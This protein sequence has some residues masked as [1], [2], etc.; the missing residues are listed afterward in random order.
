MTATV[1]DIIPP[2]WQHWSA[3]KPSVVRPLA[4]GLTN[5]SF[6]L[7]AGNEQLVLRRNSAISAAL[8]LDR[9][10]ESAALRCASAAGLC[11]PLVY[12]DPN[13][14]YVVTRYL[15]GEPLRQNTPGALQQLAQLLRSIHQLPAIDARLDIDA[16]VASY[17]HSIDER[18]DF[19]TPLRSLDQKVQRHIAAARSM[20]DGESLCHNDLSVE[21]LIFTDAG[22]LYAIDWEYAAMGDRFYDLAVIAEEHGLEKQQQQLLLAEYLGRSTVDKDWQRLLHWQVIYG[23]LAV[24]WY[25]VQWCAGA[26]AEPHI[27]DE[28]FNRVSNLSALSSAGG[29][30]SA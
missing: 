14:Q 13:H 29:R 5:Q 30:G 2:D 19:Y 15:T 10:A 12:S 6:L 23:Y 24:L 27:K 16:K 7:N 4:G 22:N 18:A 26:M 21:N 1:S 8:D 20:G 9:A 28:I 11:A 3:S 17:W 25:A